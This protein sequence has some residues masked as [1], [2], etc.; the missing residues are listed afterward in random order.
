M[1][2]LSQNIFSQAPTWEGTDFVFTQPT[3]PFVSLNIQICSKESN[4]GYISFG[5]ST[6]YFN[7]NTNDCSSNTIINELFKSSLTI[8]INK[9]KTINVHT[10]NVATCYVTI[11]N[12][13]ADEGYNVLPTSSLK[14]SYLES[15]FK[16]VAVAD[17]GVHTIIIALEDATILKDNTTLV[18][19]YT[20]QKNDILVLRSTKLGVFGN[21][22]FAVFNSFRTNIKGS[23][24]ANNCCQEELYEQLIPAQ[25]LGKIYL[26]NSIN[27]E[28]ETIVSIKPIDSLACIELNN[29]NIELTKPELFF[30][31]KPTL[32]R[33][34]SNLNISRFFESNTCSKNGI[35]D[36]ELIN[37][38]PIEYLT[39]NVI[40]HSVNG[41]FQKYFLNIVAPN[42]TLDSIY[43]DGVN[44]RS[45]FK[46]VN[47][48]YSAA[49]FEISSA[50][51]I[52]QSSKGFQA[53]TYGLS[54]TLA[55]P[56]SAA[57][58]L[59][60]ETFTKSY[61]YKINPTFT[62]AILCENEFT[63]Y[64]SN[65]SN[66][67]YLWNDGNISANRTFTDSGFYTVHVTNNCLNIDFTDTLIVEKINCQCNP[68]MPEVFSPNGDG[69]NDQIEIVYNCLSSSTFEL[70]IFNRWGKRVFENYNF[71]KTWD[72]KDF[73]KV[74]CP[75]GAYVY[76]LKYLDNRGKQN[77]KSGTIL[78]I[79]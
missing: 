48:F 77:K 62:K 71:E 30:V 60:S 64:N 34:S 78:I 16:N 22:P 70:S 27:E 13:A 66:S 29:E 54:N 31:N 12:I 56:N 1:N 9:N 42:E 35:G 49:D 8:G 33:S 25:W 3:K 7:I 43:L 19:Q 18:N 44:I 50:V 67:T 6:I 15:N 2:L 63:S 10:S 17:T 5:D 72:G 36:P 55:G 76:F 41:Y 26:L 47:N 40:F 52:L 58:N 68:E 69:I 61:K 28:V 4:T 39:K 75:A 73:N 53:F 46:S 14:E 45:K 11:Y 20:L 24:C 59:F 57:Y 23:I 32:I 51:H 37:I 21:K 79:K 74:D 65:D 38:I